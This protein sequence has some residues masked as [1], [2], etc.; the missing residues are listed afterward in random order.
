M[1]S[2]PPPWH[3]AF[4]APKHEPAALTANEVLNLLQG[5]EANP[6]QARDFVLVDLR[7]NDHEGGTIRTSLNLPAQSLYPSI[8]TLYEVFR[9]AQVKTV[10]W[11]CGELLRDPWSIGRFLMQTGSSLG[12][13][14]RAAGWL[15]DQIAEKG[16]TQ[17]RSVILRGGI[18]GCVAVRGELHVMHVWV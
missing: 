7:R 6:S 8:P 10:L 16:D 4:P 11:Y 2:T 13:G 18:K 3:A 9:A 5:A 1:S 15:G 17:M 14:S 12:R